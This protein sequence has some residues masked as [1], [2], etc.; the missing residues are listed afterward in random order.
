MKIGLSLSGGAARGLVHLGAMEELEQAGV[1]IDMIAGCSIGALIGAMYALDPNV[2]SIKERIFSFLEVSENQIIPIDYLDKS[3]EKERRGIFK[4][5]ADSLR[6]S[7]F[8]GISLTQTSLLSGERLMETLGKLVP[9]VDFSECKIPFACGTTD[10]TNKKAHYITSGSLLKAVVA[11][12]A[13]PGLYPPVKF[14][15]MSLVDGSW[16]VQ[17]HPD[18]L[19]SMGAGFVIAVNIDQKIMDEPEPSTGLEVVLRSNIAT[20]NV[21]SDLQLKGADVVIQPD[22]CD[23]SWWDFNNSKSCTIKGRES[24]AE[25]INQIKRKILAARIKR[26]FL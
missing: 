10:I 25:Q 9:D 6:K 18:K 16:A 2:G 13:I 17:N 3:G 26:F 1:P 12:C 20:R 14:D 15:G 5:I 4:R 11:S 24:T 23:I 7:V 8:Y 19:K 22:I 21:L